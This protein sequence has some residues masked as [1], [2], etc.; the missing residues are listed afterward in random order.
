MIYKIKTIYQCIY[1]QTVLTK[2]MLWKALIGASGDI[3]LIEK[4]KCLLTCKYKCFFYVSP[5]I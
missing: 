1:F 3:R 5:H 4:D 2:S